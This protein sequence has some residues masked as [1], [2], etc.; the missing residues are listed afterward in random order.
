[1]SDVACI[2]M[3]LELDTVREILHLSNC[4]LLHGARDGQ[5]E[6]FHRRHRTPECRI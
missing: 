5:L 4:L 6:Q 2:L 1:M 3:M